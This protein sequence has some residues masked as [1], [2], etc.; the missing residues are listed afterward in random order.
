MRVCNTIVQIWCKSDWTLRALLASSWRFKASLYSNMGAQHKR[1]AT[2]VYIGAHEEQRQLVAISVKRKFTHTVIPTCPSWCNSYHTR[3]K[4][5]FLTH[6]TVSKETVKKD[7]C[8]F[9]KY[10]IWQVINIWL[11]PSPGEVL[12]R[13][14]LLSITKTTSGS[15]IW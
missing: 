12:K 8:T 15:Y 9:E 2:F 5:H 6:W 7:E 14:G 11:I 13:K 10:C 3:K 1:M 4:Q